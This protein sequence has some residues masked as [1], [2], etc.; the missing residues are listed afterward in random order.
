MAGSITYREVKEAFWSRIL[1]LDLMVKFYAHF[2]MFILQ[3]DE[4][5]G[6]LLRTSGIKF[7][8]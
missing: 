1:K 4:I 3:E 2:L 8:V 6:Y 5:T 7:L